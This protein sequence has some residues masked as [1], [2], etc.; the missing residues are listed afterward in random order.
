[1]SRDADT[2]EDPM[3]LSITIEDNTSI[4]CDITTDKGHNHNQ[5]QTVCVCCGSH[6]IFWV[7]HLFSLWHI[8]ISIL[9]LTILWLM[10]NIYTGPMFSPWFPALLFI[11]GTSRLSSAIFG[12]YHTKKLSKDIIPSHLLINFWKFTL[13][14]PIII[15]S[16]HIIFATI[17]IYN[18]LDSFF[19]QPDIMILFNVFIG[20]DSHTIIAGIISAFLQLPVVL[21]VYICIGFYCLV[22]YETK[23]YNHINQ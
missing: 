4:E 19:S 9:T 2:D 8:A 3:Q 16:I 6:D 12:I 21:D 1:M 5:R 15:N 22:N 14:W 13:L 10:I 17:L 11:S 23:K 20:D 18:Y 7:L